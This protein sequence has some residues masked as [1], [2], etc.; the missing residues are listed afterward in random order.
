MATFVNS[1]YC[2]KTYSYHVSFTRTLDLVPVLLL[3]FL[4]VYD[5]LMF[6]QAFQ[7]LFVILFL[8][9][10]ANE[11]FIYLP[12]NYVKYCGFRYNA[13]TQLNYRNLPSFTV[14][15]LPSLTLH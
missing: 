1:V 9:G 14:L 6:K 8:N 13:P 5:F 15:S 4:D 10:N 2:L 12:I 11:V 3:I 7:N